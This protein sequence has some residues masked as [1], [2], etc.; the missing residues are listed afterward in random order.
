M[1]KEKAKGNLVNYHARFSH[2]Q[3]HFLGRSGLEP[4]GAG[5]HLGAY[6]RL[7][8][9]LGTAAQLGVAVA[10][11]SRRVAAYRRGVAEGKQT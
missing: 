4:C 8:G 1:S 5:E 2:V 11:D 3:D 6:H 10:D 9:D 7:D